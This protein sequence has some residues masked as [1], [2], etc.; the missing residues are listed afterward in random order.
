MV[1]SHLV[2]RLPALARG[3]G[4]LRRLLLPSA[5]RVP[6]Q[7][8]S[9]Q[10]M[11][12]QIAFRRVH[13]FADLYRATLD[14]RPAAVSEESRRVNFVM[15]GQRRNNVLPDAARAGDAMQKDQGRFL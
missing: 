11:L 9:R 5:Q 10:F 6:G 4:L 7:M 3:C 15:L 12:V 8:R 14:I 13:Q 2:V 1:P